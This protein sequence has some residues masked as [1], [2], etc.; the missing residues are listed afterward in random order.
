MKYKN[1]NGIELSYEGHKNDI[2]TELVKE[3]IIEAIKLGDEEIGLARFPRQGWAKVK[4]FLV[5]NFSLDPKVL[6]PWHHD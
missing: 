4:E 1:K 6:K 5:D 2:H 3:V